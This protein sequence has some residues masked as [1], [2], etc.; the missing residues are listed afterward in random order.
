MICD[1]VT[2]KLTTKHYTELGTKTCDLHNKMP[3]LKVYIGAGL[4]LSP[5]GRANA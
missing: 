5:G 1:K 3:N 2:K 4:T